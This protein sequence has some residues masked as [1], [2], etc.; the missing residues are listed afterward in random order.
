MRTAIIGFGEAAQTFVRAWGYA[1]PAHLR[2]FDIKTEAPETRAAK[3]DDYACLGVEGAD[4]I[5]QALDGADLV[6]SLVTADQSLRAAEAARAHLAAGALFL[7]MNSVAP[8]TKRDAAGLIELA[9]ARYVDVA[10]MAPVHETLSKVPLLLAGPHAD[11][12]LSAL[13]ALG[14]SGRVVSGGTGAAATIKMTRSIMIKG[15]E[16]LTA[17]CLLTA[18]EAGVEREVI[19]S[20]DGSFPGWDWRG[21]A[22]YGFDRMLIHGARRAEEM[23][24]SAATAD[25]FGQLGI[26]ARAT[27]EWERRLGALGLNPPPQGLDAKISA[28][29]EGLKDPSA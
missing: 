29:S 25:A 21:R 7:D 11:A 16:A 8:Q 28:I 23:R 9:G 18:R 13:A 1:R 2:A 6:L 15:I 19:A 22:D 10:V 14:F 12:G 17:E 3:L 4:R 5:G 26:M 27:A 20:L 24:E